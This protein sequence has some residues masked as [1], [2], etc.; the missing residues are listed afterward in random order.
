MIIYIKIHI[1]INRIYFQIT[2]VIRPDRY[3][4]TLIGMPWQF[5][6][7][8][9]CII[10]AQFLLKLVNSQ[11]KQLVISSN[12]SVKKVVNFYTSHETCFVFFSQFEKP[13]KKGRSSKYLQLEIRGSCQAFFVQNPKTQFGKFCRNP[14]F[15]KNPVLK[16]A[17]LRFSQICRKDQQCFLN[18]SCICQVFGSICL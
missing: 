16:M 10:R 7:K 9:C 4:I 1:K 14:V 15:S 8:M 18:Y 2:L 13:R 17:K 3:I 5:L 12:I 11:C 6:L